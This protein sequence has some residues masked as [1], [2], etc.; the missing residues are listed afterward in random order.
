MKPI[1]SVS[2]S[3]LLKPVLEKLASQGAELT[4]KALQSL[5]LAANDAKENCYR[6]LYDDSLVTGVL[7]SHGAVT[8]LFQSL[9]ID[10]LTVVDEVHAR[11]PGNLEYRKTYTQTRDHRRLER[12][13][14]RPI[15]DGST[16]R[17]QQTDSPRL[18]DSL[19]GDIT[20][21]DLFLRAL[22]MPAVWAAMNRLGVSVNK[23]RRHAKHLQV[24]VPDIESQKFVIGLDGNR[25]TFDLFDLAAGLKLCGKTDGG[26]IILPARLS[27]VTPR[28][29]ELEQQIAEFEWL[30][31][32]PGIS[33]YDIHKFLESHP[34]FL[35]G[36]EYKQLHSQLTL[37]RGD[38]PNLRPDFF[39]ERL[40]GN[41]CDILDLKLPRT[42]LNSSTRFQVR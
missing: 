29:F 19:Q 41:F 30:I 10:P 4:D 5:K 12:R 14:E 32:R 28:Q 34:H 39:L 38:Q 22:Q 6:N 9:G 1:S 7:R 18:L 26:Q 24:I 33:E 17:L 35:L 25:F 27:F 16:D 36:V 13:R 23:V 2:S 8:G 20:S 37:V 31:N 40:D 3:S 11:L 15:Q 21:N 42:K